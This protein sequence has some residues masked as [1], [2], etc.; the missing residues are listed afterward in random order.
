MVAEVESSR[1]ASVLRLEF[2]KA[3]ILES[4]SSNVAMILEC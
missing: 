4:A 3:L 2:V 1:E